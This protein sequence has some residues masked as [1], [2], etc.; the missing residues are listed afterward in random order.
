MVLT[1]VR[2]VSD[3]FSIVSLMASLLGVPLNEAG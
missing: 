2:K 3:A 1:R